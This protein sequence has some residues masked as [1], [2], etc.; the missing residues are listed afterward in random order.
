MRNILSSLF[1]K[2]DAAGKKMIY[3]APRQSPD[4]QAVTAVDDLRP[5]AFDALVGRPAGT[6]RAL[7]EYWNHSLARPFWALRAEIKAIAQG[8][9]RALDGTVRLGGAPAGPGEA[10]SGPQ[11]AEA[12][13]WIIPIDDDDWLSPSVP[14]LLREID[15]RRYD[16][17]VWTNIKV[18][19]GIEFRPD[20]LTFCFTNN[21]AVSGARV[22]RTLDWR[23]VEQ[24]FGAQPVFFGDEGPEM[25][26][27][28]MAE[29]QSAA[30]KHPCCFTHL[31][32]VATESDFAP[33]AIREAV[34]RYC[35][36]I[37]ASLDADWA[38]ADDNAWLVHP[39]TRQLEGFRRC[40][41]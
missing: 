3:L 40:L 27:V 21:Y 36:A 20:S 22:G 15:A 35:A 2:A 34:R 28:R 31:E 17:A 5:E 37:E 4:W 23:R 38:T 13:S 33:D 14:R 24:H 10:G 18:A 41:G 9:W 30:N 1:P 8:Q 7:I 26:I 12:D 6:T 32:R 29:A 11:E 19:E 39:L 16:G 25:T